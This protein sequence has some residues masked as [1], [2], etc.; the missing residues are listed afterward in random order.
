MAEVDIA[1]R[2]EGYV[3]VRIDGEV[4]LGTRLPAV[5]TLA[6]HAASVVLDLCDV[7]FFSLAGVDWVDAAVA[8]LTA[9]G[10]PVRIVCAAPGPVWRLVTLLDLRWRWAVH[11]QVAD[12]VAT[13]SERR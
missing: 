7:R 6:A 13:L 5:E 11:H 9:G 8:A 3:V 4:D 2:P 12:A 1:R 10:R